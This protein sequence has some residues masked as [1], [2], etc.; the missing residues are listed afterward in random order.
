MKPKTLFMLVLG[1]LIYVLGINYFIVTANIFSAGL[2][3]LA[4]EF[5]QTINHIFSFGWSNTSSQ[6]LTVQTFAYWA[7]NLPA[8]ILGFTKVGKKFTTKTLICSFVFIPLFMNILVSESSLLLDIDGQLTLASQVLSAVVG[9]TLTGMGMGII[10]RYGGSS[11]GTDIVAT[12]LALFK[13]KSFGKY[14]L[15][16]NLVV[17]TWAVILF[18]DFKVAILLLILIF[19]QSRAVDY[20][21]NFHD[22]VTLFAI[23]TKEDELREIVLSTPDRTYTKLNATLGYSQTEAA[24]LMIVINKEELDL[25]I[26]AFKKADP[27]CFIDVISTAS[28]SGNFE[29]RF[30]TQL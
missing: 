30:K 22:K 26:N 25:A 10:F 7:L 12:Y 5:A 2:M 9:G 17:I 13:G 11:G 4:Q 1:S 3:G 24:L 8:L 14:N 15:M 6:Y 21:Y 23:T 20:F 16:I 19:V 28:I 18:N 27:D 29:N